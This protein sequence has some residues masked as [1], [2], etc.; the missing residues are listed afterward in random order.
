M[1]SHVWLEAVRPSPKL[2]AARTPFVTCP[3]VFIQYIKSPLQIWRP[4]YIRNLRMHH[5]LL[6]WIVKK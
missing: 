3:Q 4:L 1:A 2:Q 6:I 5:V